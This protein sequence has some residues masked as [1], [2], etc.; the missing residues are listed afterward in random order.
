MTVFRKMVAQMGQTRYLIMVLMLLMMVALPIKMILRWS[1]NLQYFVNIQE[2][3][4]NI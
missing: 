4:L 3:F 1:I 2:I